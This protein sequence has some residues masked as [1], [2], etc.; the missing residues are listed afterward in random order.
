MYYPGSSAQGKHNEK[1]GGHFERHARNKKHGHPSKKSHAK[2]TATNDKDM[3]RT[4]YYD[5]KQGTAD[6]IVFMNYKGGEGSGVFDKYV[7]PP[8]MYSHCRTVD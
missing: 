6:G 3:V 4:A 7:F 5:S 2:A 1:R 8:C